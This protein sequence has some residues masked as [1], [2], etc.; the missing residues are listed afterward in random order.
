MKKKNRLAR[1]E[2]NF[3]KFII[4]AIKEEFPGLWQSTNGTLA[5]MKHGID[6]YYTEKQKTQSISA[7]V[8][9]CEPKQHFAVRWKRDIEPKKLLEV[10]SRLKALKNDSPMSNL[11]IEGFV[12]DRWAYIAWIDTKVLWECVSVHLENLN[13]FPVKNQEGG[14]TLFKQVPFGLFPQGISKKIVPII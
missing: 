5:D 4:P 9:M 13:H 6:F 10:G 14:Y 11:T 8:W 2:R 7:R 1:G 12:W 3:Q